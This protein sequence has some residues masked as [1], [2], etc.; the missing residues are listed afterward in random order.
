MTTLSPAGQAILRELVA[1]I[2]S[3]TVTVDDPRTYLG[4]KAV[5]DALGLTKLSGTFGD[6]LTEQGL[7]DLAEWTKSGPHPAIT[8]LVIDMTPG[9]PRYLTPGNGYFELFERPRNPDYPWWRGEIL[10][11]LDYDWQPFLPSASPP[12]PTPNASDIA[13]PPGREAVTIYR[14]LRDTE[15]ARRVKILHRY[16]C[17]ICG[18]TI[19]LPDGTR[20][21][22]AHHIRPLG[23]PHEGP[24]V[25]ANILCLCPNHHAAVDLGAIHLE[26]SALRTTTGHD[27]GPAYIAYHN[28]VILRRCPAG[29]P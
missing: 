25:A 17:Q 4:Y 23:G 21:A 6:S 24:D 11:S 26:I 8:G 9:N 12:A 14:I 15:I 16:E 2:E 27:V 20:Y 5:H 18:F 3:G 10:K 28:E 19:E 1:H 22:E 7:A 13:D 29:H